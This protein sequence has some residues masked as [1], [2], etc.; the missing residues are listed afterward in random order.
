MP[1]SD[2][3]G[4]LHNF[5]GDIA[6]FTAEARGGGKALA[7]RQEA[8]D[9]A[10]L[11]QREASTLAMIRSN[12]GL[13]GAFAGDAA[14][15]PAAQGIL[16]GLS[17]T[18]PVARQNALVAAAN[19]SGETGAQQLA[20]QAARAG[21]EDRKQQQRSAL[22]FQ[23][24][25]VSRQLGIQK[26]QLDL[27]ASRQPKFGADEALQA[28]RLK[29]NHDSLTNIINF[30]ENSGAIGPLDLLRQPEVV[31]L[32]EF[33]GRTDG[34]QIIKNRI[35]DQRLSNEDRQEY[36]DLQGLDFTSWLFSGSRS[37][38]EKLKLMQRGIELEQDVLAG[39]FPGLVQAHPEFWMRKT[40]AP[41]PGSEV[42]QPGAGPVQQSIGQ[43]LSFGLP[44]GGQF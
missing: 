44:V 4:I 20:L 5:F 34:V 40:L 16:S 25:T 36:F 35:G 22:Q 11:G 3:G 24:E 27:A 21:V 6:N 17:S 12:R 19:I 28:G 7:R 42:V 15:T 1:H 32:V 23:Q 8:E 29:Q 18:D 39:Q 41:P 33:F 9:A 26:Q 43:G 31:A 10:A 13:S 38:V 2:E 30:R 37:V 14:R